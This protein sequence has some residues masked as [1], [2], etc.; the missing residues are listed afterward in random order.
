MGTINVTL[1]ATIMTKIIGAITT[2]TVMTMYVITIEI[3]GTLGTGTV[4]AI[5]TTA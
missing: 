1:N 5:G 3:T 4:G 2:M